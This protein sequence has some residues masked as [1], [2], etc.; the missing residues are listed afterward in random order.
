MMVA[1]IIL[2]LA[3]YKVIMAFYTKVISPLITSNLPQVGYYGVSGLPLGRVLSV[4]MC[5]SN[6]KSP[7]PFDPVFKNIL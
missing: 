7:F 3:M 6:I 5:V 4:S 1:L 2:M